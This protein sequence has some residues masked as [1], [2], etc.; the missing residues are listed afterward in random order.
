MVRGGGDESH[1]CDSSSAA[2]VDSDE[3]EELRSSDGGFSCDTDWSV[4]TDARSSSSEDEGEAE[5]VSDAEI[6]PQDKEEN[7]EDAAIA[8]RSAQLSSQARNLGLA[9]ALWSSL[10]CDIVL[11]KA[12]G[13]DLF[14]LKD[15]AGAMSTTEVF[16]VPSSLAA[17]AV[18]MALL[19]SGFA[20]AALVS[21]MLW[22]DMDISAEAMVA[23]DGES[24]LGD[25]IL[26]LSSPEN[27]DWDDDGM[28][29][30]FASEVRARLCF[31]LSLFGTLC[32]AA[33]GGL[34]FSNKAPFLGMSGAIINIHN[35]LACVSA[36]LKEERA[37]EWLVR[38]ATWPMKLFQIK[39]KGEERGKKRVELSS[40]I[41]RLAAGMACLCCFPVGQKLWALVKQGFL[42]AN[43]PGPNEALVANNAR[44]LS[45]EVVSL[46]RLTLFAGV[47]QLLHVSG[48]MT[49][50]DYDISRHPFFGV[51]S[52]G[53]GMGSVG[54]GGVLLWDSLR[55]SLFNKVRVAAEGVL[56]VVFGLFSGYHSVTG[57]MARS[58]A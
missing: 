8:Q 9:T 1:M 55:S 49:Q 24:H 58:K 13:R 23:E 32:L 57:V 39:D 38:A 17:T 6:Q 47:S 52:G 5:D 22:R 50:H 53:L 19:A 33:H 51:L 36:L 43:A 29:R 30:K 3:A 16:A 42:L 54:L 7:D 34:Y 35:T 2:E 14:F 27:N 15:A 37:K 10:L 12:K 56:L 40:F 4:E 48:S 41:F 44:L 26:A 25:S 45:L 46:A 11:N 20:L 28:M 31:H 21:F 18:P